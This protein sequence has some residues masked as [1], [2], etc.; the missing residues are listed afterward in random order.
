MSWTITPQ[1]K[2]PVDPQ[3]GSVSLLLHGNADGSGNILD[4]SPTPKTISKFGNAASA[5]PPSYPNSNSTFGNAIAFDGSGDYL[6]FSQFLLINDFTLEAWVYLNVSNGDGYLASSSGGNDQIIRFSSLSISVYV[7]ASYGGGSGQVISSTSSGMSAGAWSHV[8]LCR[9]AGTTRLFVDGIV[10]A[11]NTTWTSSVPVSNIG[12]S[13][14][15]NSNFL[16]GYVDDLRIT[17]G[18]ARYTANFTPP[19]APFPD[20]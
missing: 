17:K 3:Y 4:S 20:I 6:T 7:D 10:K 12:R 15:F 2:V 13:A 1:T 5:T 19:A 14:I 9:A 18:I 16:N 8:A 11:T